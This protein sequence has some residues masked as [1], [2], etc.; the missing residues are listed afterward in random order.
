MKKISICIA[1]ITKDRVTDL[2][3][4]ID[5]LHNQTVKA[6]EIIVVDSSTDTKTKQLMDRE[7]KKWRTC[8]YIFEQRKG[9]PIARNRALRKTTA[10]WIA[11]TDDDCIVDKQWIASLAQSIRRH[12]SAA[13]IAG[14]S[15]TAYPD[16]L[17]ACAT[18]ANEWYWK[19]ISRQK[20]RITD[21]ESLDNKNVAYNRRFLE[22]HHIT[23]DEHR[24]TEYLGASDD[25]DIGMQIQQAGG[26]AFFEK[27]M[28]VCHKDKTDFI[29]YCIWKYRSTLAHAS[30][31]RKWFHSRNAMPHYIKPGKIPFLFRYTKLKNM[32]LCSTLALFLILGITFIIIRLAKF[33]YH[34]RYGMTHKNDSNC[35]HI[36]LQ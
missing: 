31:E 36:P 34:V 16:N 23:Y 5:S 24:V 3:R 7:R 21:L 18:E 4:C 29:S 1:I 2:A 35:P 30:Y 11:F 33:E 12:P 9:F 25:C 26:Y 28:I 10:Q 17:I 20:N 13:A 19:Y 22:T 15:N 32:S 14:Q 8:T 27:K 6:Q